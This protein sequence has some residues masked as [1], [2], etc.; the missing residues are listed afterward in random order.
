MSELGVNK[1]ILI[2]RSGV[3][4]ELKFT[5]AGK[6]VANFSLAVN[7]SFKNGKGELQDRVQWV[8]CVAWH[9]AAEIAGQYISKGKQVYVEGRLQTRKYDD[10]EGKARTITEVVITNLRL[11]GGGSKSSSNNGRANGEPSQAGAANGSREIADNE[12]PF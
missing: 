3:D 1:V 5:P 12:I 10:K 4:A 11:L 2:G 7:E 9:K 6:P 8:R